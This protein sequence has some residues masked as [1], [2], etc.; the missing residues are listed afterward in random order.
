MNLLMIN[1]SPRIKQQS[2]TQII[3]EAFQKGFIEETKQATKILCLSERNHWNEIMQEMYEHETI[4]I[5]MPLYVESIPG[6]M[7]EFLEQLDLEKMKHKKLCFLL[8]GGFAEA[9]QLWCARSYLEKLP[10]YL[11]CDYGGTLIKGDMFILHL[12]SPVQQKKSIAPFYE[13]GKRFA[14]HPSF[15]AKEVDCFAGPAFFSKRKIL[16]LTLLRP[17]QRIVVFVFAR[18]LGCRQSLKARPYQPWVK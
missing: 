2:N 5:A 3:L 9:S 8:Q 17:I 12:L 10:S 1:A 6:I 13:M 18:K 4:L 15:D 11:Q 7:M 16:I 14:K